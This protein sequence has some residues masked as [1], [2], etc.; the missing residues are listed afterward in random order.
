MSANRSIYLLLLEGVPGSPVSQQLEALEGPLLGLL[1]RPGKHLHTTSDIISG[2]NDNW[3]RLEPGTTICGLEHVVGRRIGS[4][5]EFMENGCLEKISQN[6][7][8]ILGVFTSISIEDA[9][10]EENWGGYKDLI[11]MADAARRKKIPVAMYQSDAIKLA[12]AE[13]TKELREVAEYLGEKV[14]RVAKSVLSDIQKEVTA[15][16]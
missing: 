9:V 3:E 12:N 15:V 16:V 1:S 4:L 7:Y 6:G 2:V 8:K 13:G 14:K 10:S 11:E 5:R